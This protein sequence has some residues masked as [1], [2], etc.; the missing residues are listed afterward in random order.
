MREAPGQQFHHYSKWEDWHAG[1]YRPRSSSPGVAAAVALLG[2][3]PLFYVNAERVIQEWPTA[4][5][6]NLS[7]L[8]ANHQPWLGRAA[9]C[10]YA[11]ATIRDT[12][13]AWSRLTPRTQRVANAVADYVC[14]S[15]RRSH[16]G[17]QLR[18]TL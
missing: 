5:A 1:M 3:P 2:A 4:T 7:N 17:G 13:A 12:S 14:D 16:M 10:L 8:Y 6:Q 18:W 9:C 11:G 15:W